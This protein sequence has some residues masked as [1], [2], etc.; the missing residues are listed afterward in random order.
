M[1]T[2]TKKVRQARSG[3]DMIAFF[4]DRHF[5]DF[6][7]FNRSANALSVT[8]AK[9]EDGP[10]VCCYQLRLDLLALEMQR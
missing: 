9:P 8:D 2:T 4:C 5:R 1:N 7:A 10:C 3:G 6:I